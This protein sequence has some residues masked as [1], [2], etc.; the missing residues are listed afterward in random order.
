MTIH[1]SPAQWDAVRNNYSAWWEGTL[2]R[3]LGIATLYGLDPGRACPPA[4]LLT[5]DTCAD[6]R[7]AA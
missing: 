3:P 2:E 4:P 5:H 6:I 7:W 1:F